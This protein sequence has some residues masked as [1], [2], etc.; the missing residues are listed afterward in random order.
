MDS[1][2][3]QNTSCVIARLNEEVVRILHTPETRAVF[4]N[5]G[6]EPVG[7]KPEEFGAIIKDE[8][9]KWAKA[10]RAAGIKAD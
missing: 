6:A 2:R 5:E 1:E 3:P 10:I 8:T 4:T 9:A 7:N